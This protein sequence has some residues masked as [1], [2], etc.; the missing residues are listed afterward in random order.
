MPRKRVDSIK[1]FGVIS[2]ELCSEA[3]LEF[4]RS[5]ISQGLPKS[6]I[7]RRAISVYRQV[8]E[9]NV[10]RDKLSTGKPAKKDMRILES[11]DKNAELMKT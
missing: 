3:D 9:A 4:V 2:E 10:N 8:E 7:V 6:A 1:L 11:I 5:L